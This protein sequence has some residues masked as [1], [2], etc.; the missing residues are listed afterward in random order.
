[1]QIRRVVTMLVCA[2]PIAALLYGCGSSNKEGSGTLADVATVS[3]ASCLGCHATWTEELTG[4]AIVADHNASLHKTQMVGCQDCHGGGSQHNGV[5]PLPYP[6]PD[7]NQCASCHNEIATAFSSSN[8]LVDFAIEAGEDHI[9]CARCHTHQGAI[10]SN[11]TGFTGDKT[12]MDSLVGAPGAI[13]EADAKS[14]QCVTCHTTHKTDELRTVKTRDGSGNIIDW[15]PSTTVGA[16]TPSTNQQFNM[17][18]SCHTYTNPDGTLVASG[19]AADG[20]TLKPATAPYYHNTAWYRTIA[21]THWD[22]PATTAIVEGYVLRTNGTNNTN[23]CFDCHGHESKTGTRYGNTTTPAPSIHSDWAESAH[24]G[25]ILTAKYDAA[26][27]LGNTRSQ[28][29]VDAVMVAGEIGRAHV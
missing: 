20:V 16:A 7:H 4:R 10:I 19:T 13:A 21:T 27:A 11:L 15:Q 18:T 9:K 6:T 22:N 29:T 26:T 23:P 5:G 12:I 1:M 8:H 3:E 28:A 2:L 25:K 17:C 14:V 24:G